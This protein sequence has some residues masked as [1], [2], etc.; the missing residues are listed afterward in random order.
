ML[1][2][3]D[4]DVDAEWLPDSFTQNDHSRCFTCAPVRVYACICVCSLI[5]IYYTC[6]Q[7]H[8]ATAVMRENKQTK[9]TQPNRTKSTSHTIRPLARTTIQNGKAGAASVGVFFLFSQRM[10]VDFIV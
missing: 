7:Y 8:C 9:Q 4:I 6:T 2:I 10:Y 3:N 5:F 1:T